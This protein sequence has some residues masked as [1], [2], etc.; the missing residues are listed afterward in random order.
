M[1]DSKSYSILPGLT[2]SET[3]KKVMEFNIDAKWR[4][5]YNSW[6]LLFVITNIDKIFMPIKL[7]LP[8]VLAAEPQNYKEVRVI[9][10][11]TI[12]SIF[13]RKYNN[14]SIFLIIIILKMPKLF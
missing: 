12:G 9:S 7:L 13:A 3:P 5:L 2:V 8:T 11:F 10:L 4:D 14:E 1:D 6:N